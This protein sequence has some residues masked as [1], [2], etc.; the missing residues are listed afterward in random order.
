MEPMDI[1]WKNI[2][3]RF[4]QDDLYEHINAPKWFDFSAPD[5]SVDD[6]A[7]FC[8]PDCQHPKSADDFKVNNRLVRSATRW[9]TVPLGERNPR[10]ANLKRR[11]ILST[12]PALRD[13]KSEKISSKT[14]TKFREDSENENPNFSSSSFSTITTPLK[15]SKI[16][17]KDSIKSST[18]KARKKKKK[19]PHADSDS[20]SDS[21]QEEKKKLRSTRSARNLFAGREILNQ[22][23][24]FC[25][26]LKK[27]ALNVTTEREKKRKKKKEKEEEPLLEEISGEGEKMRTQ[28]LNSKIFSPQDSNNEENEEEI[29]VSSVLK[30]SGGTERKSLQVRSCPP[31]PQRFPS[32]CNP[33]KLTKTTTFL[34]P[35]KS[36]VRGIIQNVEQNMITKELVV[37]EDEE[38]KKISVSSTEVRP[39]LDM[40]WFFKPCTYLAE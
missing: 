28:N 22:V 31:T 1:D 32:P 10:D 33:Q 24:E 26:E 15:S 9:E 39:P 29:H 37:E 13:F 14:P 4:I 38:N 35:P 17:I 19:K 7:W 11:G 12:I 20:D 5:E 18:E 23:T 27:L 34:K 8:R 3:S 30:E 6:E 25:S 2:D 40:F 21:L 16:N 36:R